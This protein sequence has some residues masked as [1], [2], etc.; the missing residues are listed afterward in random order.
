MVGGPVQHDR[1]GTDSIMPTDFRPST[2]YSLSAMMPDHQNVG[3]SL[4]D[5][6]QPKSCCTLRAPGDYALE[7]LMA[8]QSSLA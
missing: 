1:Q 4:G 3:H 6:Q 5:H 7:S 8:S 2:L